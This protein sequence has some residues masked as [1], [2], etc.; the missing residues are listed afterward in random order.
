MLDKKDIKNIKASVISGNNE[1]RNELASNSID[2]LSNIV[3]EYVSENDSYE[4]LL[5]EGYILL[6]EAAYKYNVNHQYNFYNFAEKYIRNGLEEYIKSKTMTRD[7]S[8]DE[9]DYTYDMS[10]VFNKILIEQVFDSL[11]GVSTFDD[12]AKYIIRRYF[13]FDGNKMSVKELSEE[14][15][16]STAR[17]NE[18]L[19]K[20]LYM[21][22]RNYNIDKNEETRKHPHAYGK[23]IDKNTKM[24]YNLFR[25]L[26]RGY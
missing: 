1:A 4:E 7:I 21:I 8:I 2:F 16:I 6:T 13:G 3:N 23:Q 20:C 24:W 5:S 25:S 19:R 17:I 14:L 26:K 12:R 11:K 22:R 18:I 15:H 9:A 10:N